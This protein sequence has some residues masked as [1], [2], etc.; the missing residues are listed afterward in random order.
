MLGRPPILLLWCCALAGCYIYR[1]LAAPRPEPATYLAV[2]LTEAGSEDLARYIGPDVR[3]VRGR[4]QSTNARGL[5]VSVS[6][7]E[8]RCVD[9]LSWQG[10][11]GGV[12][13]G[14]VASLVE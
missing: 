1:P 14:F 4:L 12:P 5:T 7:V 3:V 9:V 6:P 10:E 8:L 2:T 11:T 13:R